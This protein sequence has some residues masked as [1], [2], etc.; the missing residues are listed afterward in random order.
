MDERI[1]ERRRQVRRERQLRR[2]RRTLLVAAGI[3]VAALLVAL[4]RSP[5]VELA[6]VRVSGTERLSATQV[7]RVAGLELGTSTLR[8]PLDEA[9]RRIEAL[10]LVR[11]ARV[12]RIDPLTVELV[13]RERTP[14]AVVV[15]RG[16][17]AMI[18]RAG[19]VIVRGRREGLP[20]IDL[21]QGR[22]PEPGRSVSASP[23]LRA[24][25]RVLTELPGPLRAEVVRYRV[26]AS[27]RLVLVLPDGVEVSFGRPVEIGEKVRAL[28]VVLEDL[29]R[30]RVRRID[31]RAPRTPVIEPA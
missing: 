14:I 4:E 26:P 2:L 25:H 8:L 9:E 23:A 28:G 15:G 17:P 30:R 13:V 31:V 19:V 3:V 11:E 22:V 10:P 7:R 20:V 6:E 1:L 24:A 29:G 21:G 5:L 16:E 12:R 27:D 18:D